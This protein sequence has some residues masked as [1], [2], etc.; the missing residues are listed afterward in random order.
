MLL[1]LIRFKSNKE[2]TLGKLYIDGQFECFTLE[3]QKQKTKVMHET[4]IPEGN[5]NIKLR[6]YGKW[7]SRFQEKFPA[8]HKGM[9]QICDVPGFSDILIHTGNT[10]DDSS[11][12]ILVG[13]NVDEINFR[14]LAGQST[15]AYVPMYTKVLSAFNKKDTVRIMIEDGEVSNG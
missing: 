4:R 12:C 10:D 1:R 6:T 5:Y 15:A 13:K 7:H 2:A 8:L 11:G 9:L 3:D 14:I